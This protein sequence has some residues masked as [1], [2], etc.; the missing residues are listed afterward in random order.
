MTSGRSL[1]Y[2]KNISGPKIDP[3][4]T[5]EPTRAHPDV[6]PDTNIRVVS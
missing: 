5:P 3:C 6:S 1:I 2:N 4:G